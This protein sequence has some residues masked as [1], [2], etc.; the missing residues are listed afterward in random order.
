M[1]DRCAPV[2]RRSARAGAE[3]EE[4]GRGPLPDALGRFTAVRLVR[5]WRR[6]RVHRRR[7]GRAR[8]DDRRPRG[9]AGR[10]SCGSFDVGPVG[11][12]AVAGARVQGAGTDRVALPRH[13][14]R[15]G[16]DVDSRRAAQPASPRAAREVR[17]ARRADRVLRRVERRARA[18]DRRVRRPFQPP[19]R[20]RA[21][22]RK[23]RPR[24][25]HVDREGRLRR[26]RHRAAARQSVAPQRAPRRH[27]VPEG[28]HRRRRHARR[29]RVDGP[30]PARSRPDRHAGGASPPACTSR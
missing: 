28:R 13:A 24:V 8:V 20:R 18:D 10:R 27:P 19:R 30:R 7:R 25:T 12:A 5:R 4:V 23:S 22:R 11:R 15:A 26:G 17:T 14:R 6:A 1:A 21:G 9:A 29:R 2:A 16:L 3:S